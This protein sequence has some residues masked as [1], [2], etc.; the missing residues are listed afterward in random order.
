MLIIRVLIVDLLVVEEL[1]EGFLLLWPAVGGFDVDPLLGVVLSHNLE[2]ELVGWLE[3]LGVGGISV[4]PVG[5]GVAGSVRCACF[6][7]FLDDGLLNFLR[8]CVGDHAGDQGIS[9]V[10]EGGRSVLEGC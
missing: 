1:L 6:G 8:G 2:H 7:H 5:M 4:L 3:E 9:I 10:H